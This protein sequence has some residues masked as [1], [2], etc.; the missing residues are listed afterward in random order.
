MN[1]TFSC[2]AIAGE[3]AGGCFTLSCLPAA[4]FFLAEKEPKMALGGWPPPKNPRYPQRILLV[5]LVPTLIA[6]SFLCVLRFKSV[7]I[8]VFTTHL[9]FGANVPA[10]GHFRVG[11]V[12]VSASSFR[13]GLFLSHFC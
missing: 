8:Q 10:K 12:T 5:A 7:S 9:R 13:A 1:E 4:F 6:C 3:V 2:P 11:E